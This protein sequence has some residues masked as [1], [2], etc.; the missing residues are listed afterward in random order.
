MRILRP[1]TNGASIQFYARGAGNEG[2]EGSFVKSKFPGNPN[3]HLPGARGKV[4]ES[5]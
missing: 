1:G 2:D 4:K 5:G 3:A